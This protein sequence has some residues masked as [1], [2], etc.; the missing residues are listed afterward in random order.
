MKKIKTLWES[1]G[2]TPNG[3]SF[4]TIKMAR[5]YYVYAER[6]GRD[7][8]AFI[9]FN[10]KTKQFGLILETKPPMD[11]RENKESQMIT[12]FGGSIDMGDKVTYQEICKT[13]VLEEAGYVVPLDRILFTGVSPVSTQM[14]QMCSTYLVD[15]TD[16]QK[17]EVAEYES[18]TDNIKWMNINELMNNGE[19]KSI[20][21]WCNA[22][23]KDFIKK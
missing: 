16:I 1:E 6:G 5:D 8:I 4:M 18:S 9:L 3:D 10:N 20:Y 19:W 13:E 2:K 12:A 15:I 7:S 21:I 14:S 17:T 22:V 11:E 23:Y